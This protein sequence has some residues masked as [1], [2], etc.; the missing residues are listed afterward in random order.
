MNILFEFDWCGSM[1]FAFRLKLFLLLDLIWIST[2]R[3]RLLI[4][5][6]ISHWTLGI[7][8]FTSGT[9]SHWLLLLTAILSGLLTT[10]TDRL[11]SFWF[12]WKNN[13]WAPHRSKILWHAS[14]TFL[15]FLK[16]Q[17]KFTFYISSFRVKVFPSE[18]WS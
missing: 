5:L 14:S 1:H 17:I 10:F 3:N 12:L 15:F 7:L 4:L 18:D 8:N 13:F 2:L 6:L 11:L 16:L 9:A